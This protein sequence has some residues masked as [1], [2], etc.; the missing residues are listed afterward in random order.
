M[1]VK[2][3]RELTDKL[4]VDAILI[5]VVQKIFFFEIWKSYRFSSC[6]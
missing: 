4:G 5:F 6:K 3:V 2:A 1:T